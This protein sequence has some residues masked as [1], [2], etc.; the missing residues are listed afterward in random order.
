[1]EEGVATVNESVKTPIE[2]KMRGRPRVDQIRAENCE[3]R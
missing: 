1:M 3:I 2:L